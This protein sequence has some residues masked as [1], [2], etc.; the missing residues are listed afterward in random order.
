MA[1]TKIYIEEPSLETSRSQ[2]EAAVKEAAETTTESE[3]TGHQP[4]R[5]TKRKSPRTKKPAVHYDC[6]VCG[7]QFKKRSL[8]KNHERVHR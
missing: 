6:A 2:A 4:S 8:R 1:E 5:K 3:T 7:K